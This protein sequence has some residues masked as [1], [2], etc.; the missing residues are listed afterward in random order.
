MYA[1]YSWL[2]LHVLPVV[3]C[4]CRQQSL[5]EQLRNTPRDHPLHTVNTYNCFCYINIDLCCRGQLSEQL[6]KGNFT[7][8]KLTTDLYYRIISILIWL[9][10]IILVLMLI[11]I[12][13]NQQFLSTGSCKLCMPPLRDTKY[14]STVYGYV[15]SLNPYLRWCAIFTFGW[16]SPGLSWCGFV[17]SFAFRFFAFLLTWVM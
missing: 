13:F 1:Y 15:Y 8:R 6:R 12:L 9:N 7:A 17:S 3:N 4:V 11:G 10:H 16:R 14:A 2:I 5:S